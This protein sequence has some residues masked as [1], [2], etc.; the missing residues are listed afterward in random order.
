VPDATDGDRPEGRAVLVRALCGA[1]VPLLLVVGGWLDAH[2]TALRNDGTS[3]LG[4][5]LAETDGRVRADALSR[6]E[7]ALEYAGTLAPWDPLT[8]ASRAVALRE[9]S[10]DDAE[11]AELRR[12][13]RASPAQARAQ[14][15]L[16]LALLFRS[17]RSEGQLRAR[18]WGPL[19]S[20]GERRLE[21]ALRVGPSHPVV[22]LEAGLHD[23]RVVAFTGE[24]DRLDRAIERIRRALALD[25]GPRLQGEAQRRVKA[26]V[27]AFPSLG[28]AGD[29]ALAALRRAPDRN[30]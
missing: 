16:A 10:N 17:E 8:H 28:K 25:P 30:P 13:V 12:A 11:L 20:E 4:R 24:T 18:D 6:A 26:L 1:V 29:A 23:L 14:L 15:E 27:E 3:S 2:A 5:A 22:W 7:R 9:L 19:R 21:V